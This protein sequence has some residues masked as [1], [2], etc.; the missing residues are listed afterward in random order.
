MKLG[1]FNRKLVA[2]AE[3]ADGRRMAP[4]LLRCLDDETLKLHT[5]LF[6]DCSVLV[7]MHPDEATEAIVDAALTLGK[8]FAIVPCCV[9]SRVFPD[10]QC[11]DGTAVDTYETF[12]KY[13]LE[14]HPSV[15]SAFLPFAGRNQV[16][17]LFDY[18]AGRDVNSTEAP[19]T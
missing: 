8:P 15:R 14:K 9:M 10:R 11:R 1:K 16:L 6:S 13:L 17:Y 19:S 18:E 7:G 3:A 12:V 2:K 4:Q 5:E